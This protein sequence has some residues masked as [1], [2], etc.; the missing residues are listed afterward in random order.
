VSGSPPL[1]VSPL[2]SSRSSAIARLQG[3]SS[4][5]PATVF[6]RWSST[7]MTTNLVVERSEPGCGLPPT[8]SFK[9]VHHPRWGGSRA[10][11]GPC[12]LH[13]LVTR[14]FLQHLEEKD[15]HPPCGGG[16][17]RL[18][19]A[20]WL[21]DVSCSVSGSLARMA[22]VLPPTL[23]PAIKWGVAVRPPHGRRSRRAQVRCTHSVPCTA[24]HVVPTLSRGVIQDV[25]RRGGGGHVL[26]WSCP[27]PRRTTGARTFLHALRRP[28]SSV[29]HRC[30]GGR[31]HW[32]GLPV[33]EVV[34]STGGGG[35]LQRWSPPLAGAARCR[36]GRLRLRGLPVAEVVA[37][38]GKAA[39]CRGGCL[40][41]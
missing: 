15:V 2:G 36:G 41:W 11:S 12:P 28:P 19:G 6:R 37:A 34:A 33:G 16:E 40:R 13:G 14:F 9:D 7:R 23:P 21:Q 17:P 24:G 8:L 31:L 5:S 39:Q 10:E 4:C 30:R 35:P 3:F 38:A 20:G 26:G 22:L 25:V 27:H 1:A 29:S 18:R 32:W